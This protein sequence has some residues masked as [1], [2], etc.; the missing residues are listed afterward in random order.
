M[1][2]S[3]K[4]TRLFITTQGLFILKNILHATLWVLFLFSSGSQLRV[5]KKIKLTIHAFQFY[6]D[7]FLAFSISPNQRKYILS[8]CL[9]DNLIFW[10]LLNFLFK[11]FFFLLTLELNVNYDVLCLYRCS[12]FLKTGSKFAI[13]LSWRWKFIVASCQKVNKN[14]W[15]KNETGTTQLMKMPSLLF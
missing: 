1:K 4:V 9:N 12:L 13:G 2:A 11:N 14:I 5:C 3:Q 10:K 15:G 8:M 6:W 7:T